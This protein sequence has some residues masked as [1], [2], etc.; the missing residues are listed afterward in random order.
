[1]KKAKKKSVKTFSKEPVVTIGIDLAK[2]SVHVF[3]VDAEG[4]VVFSRKLARKALS[5]FIAQQPTCR[6]AMEACSGAHH[7]ART[8]Q[9]FGHEVVLIAPQ[10]VKPFVKTNKNDAVDAEAICEAA[11]CSKRGPRQLFVPI[12]NVEQQDTQG[13][14]RMRSM[15]IDQR[16]ALVNQIRG[17]LAEYGIVIAQGRA[18]LMRR[19]PDIL[20]D[21]E[22]GLSERFRAELN[23]LLEELR[24]MDTRVKHYDTQIQAVANTNDSAQLLMSIPGIGPLVATALIAT[25][26]ENWG[27]FNNGRALAA[28]LGL[29][30][31]QHSTGGKPRLLG[32]S[33]RGDVYMRKLLI[34]GARAPD[35]N[36]GRWVENKDDALS[37]W[38]RGLKQRRHA[39]VAVV[40]M[41]N[42]LVRIAWAVMTTGKAFDAARGALAKPAAV[43]A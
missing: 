33:K 41:A 4:E 16:T 26:G 29:V 35:L 8:F 40:A 21:A 36:N 32:I 12:K 17:L 28:W 14:H 5:Q 7:W 34:N 42:K 31:R 13:T 10:H 6:I 37:H 20:E 43:T 38:A 18:E 2:N 19:L 25:L 30:P 22:N 24:H 15:V 3:G 9:G 11:P 23:V 39:N 1:M 27:L